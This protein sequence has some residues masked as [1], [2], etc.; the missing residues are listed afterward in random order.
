MYA[1]PGDAFM[2][3]DKTFAL[4]TGHRVRRAYAN[5]P[6]ERSHFQ[7]GNI[8]LKH[9]VRVVPGPIDG[10][11]DPKVL[12]ERWQARDHTS[13]VLEITD[14]E[15][16]EHFAELAARGWHGE[17]SVPKWRGGPPEH[18]GGASRYTSL[19][20]REGRKMSH[21]VDQI[22]NP[23]WRS[24]GKR[25]ADVIALNN[26][27]FPDRYKNCGRLDEHLALQRDRRVLLDRMVKYELAIERFRTNPAAMAQRE[28]LYDWAYAQIESLARQDEIGE[29]LFAVVADHE[30]LV[31]SSDLA[32]EN[33]LAENELRRQLSILERTSARLT[34]RTCTALSEAEAA[35]KAIQDSEQLAAT[36]DQALAASSQAEMRAGSGAWRGLV[37]DGDLVSLAGVAA[38]GKDSG[39]WTEDIISQARAARDLA[40][41][42]GFG[43]DEEESAP[44]FVRK[45]LG[46]ADGWST[47]AR[48]LMRTR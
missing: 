16:S 20:G 34:Q 1:G 22:F 26:V 27:P 10:N 11:L 42:V 7:S 13:P 24:P 29:A 48:R 18:P 44:T 33:K 31:P 8:W 3:T 35:Q 14:S 19:K 40:R 12:S 37:S 46:L 15:L 21:S 5:L 38:S 32:A 9:L 41:S 4:A 17:L 36:I 25:R 47:A 30:H 28:Q 39:A 23:C 6:L 2:S 43:V 45:R